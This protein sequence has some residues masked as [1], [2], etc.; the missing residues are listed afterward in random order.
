MCA[1]LLA[2][3]VPAW[4]TDHSKDEK[5]LK[6]ATTVLA[7]ML[8]S[9]TVPSS[10]LTTENCVLILHVKQ[11]AVGV[12]KSGGR[13]P[14]ICRKGKNFSNHR[15][16]RRLFPPCFVSGRDFIACPERSRRVSTSRFVFHGPT[17]VRDGGYPA[18]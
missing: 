2:M 9:G 6:H 5:A 18:S 11:F 7:A 10:L 3:A 4:G 14:L 15:V 13:G 12:G 8:H 1:L 17:L 16:E